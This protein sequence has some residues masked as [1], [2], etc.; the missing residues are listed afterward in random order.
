M[1]IH[2][3]NFLYVSHWSEEERVLAAKIAFKRAREYQEWLGIQDAKSD[4]LVG[5]YMAYRR[6]GNDFIPIN[7][8]GYIRSE[9]RSSSREKQKFINVTEVERLVRKS[10]F[11]EE[12]KIS[13]KQLNKTR[14]GE[15][16][17]LGTANDFQNSLDDIDLLRDIE[18]I[19]TSKEYKVV[20][21]YIILDHKIR[22]Y[23]KSVYQT[24]LIK[25]RDVLYV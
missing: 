15:L 21:R 20:C 18:Q 11:D 8:E 14:L 22:E 13:N 9:L 10:S 19:L 1:F 6:Y 17:C 24:A 25:I 7:I 2:P 23:E 12:I 3:D 4:V 5:V 16:V